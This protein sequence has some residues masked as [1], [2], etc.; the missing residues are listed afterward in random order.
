MEVVAEAEEAGAGR[1]GAGAG[2]VAVIAADDA[3]ETGEELLVGVFEAE[4]GWRVRWR[5][6]TRAV[7]RMVWLLSGPHPPAP[8][9]ILGEGED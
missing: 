7:R 5:E 2:R 3:V 9:P 1:L 4:G 6:R 8:L